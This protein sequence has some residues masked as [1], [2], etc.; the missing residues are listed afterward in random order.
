MLGLGS[1]RWWGA[2]RPAAG[3]LGNDRLFGEAGRDRLE[4]QNGCDWLGGGSGNDRLY[5]G[6]GADALHGGWRRDRLD[7]GAHG[8]RLTGG[9]GADVFVF[10]GGDDHI[11]DLR[12]AQGDRILLD[13]A[14]WPGDLEPGEVIR[15]FAHRHE[16]GTSLELAWIIHEAAVFCS[17]GQ[18]SGARVCH[19]HPASAS[20]W[21]AGR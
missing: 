13:D 4:G 16:G 9:P 1:A 21:Q 12:A 18:F 10:N 2:Q 17:R 19:A 6:N 20:G 11:V 15:R 5:G 14:L 7:G 3:G 8:D